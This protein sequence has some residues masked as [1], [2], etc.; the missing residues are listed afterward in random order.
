MRNR[1]GSFLASS[2]LVHVSGAVIPDTQ[3]GLSVGEGLLVNILM[4]SVGG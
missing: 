1:P 4:S 2:S 3:T